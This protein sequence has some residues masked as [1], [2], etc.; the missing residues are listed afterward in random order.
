MLVKVGKLIIPVDFIVLDIEEDQDIP[1][2]LGQPFLAMGNVVIN[3]SKGELS[4]NVENEKFTS[5]YLEHSKIHRNLRLVVKS[6]H[7]IRV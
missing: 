2:I 5:T 3:I 7:W 6:S 4:L 1:I